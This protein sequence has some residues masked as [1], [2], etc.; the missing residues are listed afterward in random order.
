MAVICI[1]GKEIIGQSNFLCS[2]SS[3]VF[4]IAMFDQLQYQSAHITA[5]QKSLII[6]CGLCNSDIALKAF[7]CL[8]AFL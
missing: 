8:N 1:K 7:W 3:E 6:V 5:L 2:C 4:T